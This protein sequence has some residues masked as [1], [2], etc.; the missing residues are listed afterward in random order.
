MGVRDD[1]N[2]TLRIHLRGGKVALG[3]DQSLGGIRLE[4]IQD[5]VHPAERVAQRQHP[6][7]RTHHSHICKMVI[8]VVKLFDVF[9]LHVANGRWQSARRIREWML[10]AIQCDAQRI[11]EP[12]SWPVERTDHFVIYRPLF[13]KPDRAIRRILCDAEVA[14]LTTDFLVGVVG[15]EERV[16]T[17]LEEVVKHLCASGGVEVIGSAELLREGAHTGER[18]VIEVRD[19]TTPIAL[20]KEEVLLGVWLSHVRGRERIDPDEPLRNGLYLQEIK[21]E[22]GPLMDEP[23]AHGLVGVIQVECGGAK[24]FNR[25]ARG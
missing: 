19:G 6:R 8:L 11:E 7:Q 22:S 23:T 9:R 10:A 20:A 16:D 12:S 21:G 4:T 5:A 24:T 25:V 14:N 13:L 15:M 18:H 3:L 17:A 2:R 1:V